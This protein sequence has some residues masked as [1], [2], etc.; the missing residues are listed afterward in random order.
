M[1]NIFEP[2]RL[3]KKC[4]I[5]GLGV[6]VTLLYI[7]FLI[8]LRWPFSIS[9]LGTIAIN[10]FG[11]FLAGV[12]GPIAILWLIL[13]FMLQK[14]E[15]TQNRDA[16]LLQAKELHDTLEQHKELVAATKEQLDAD[17]KANELQELQLQIDTKPHFVIKMFSK[18]S[19]SSDSDSFQENENLKSG[20]IENNRS[21]YLVDFLN[22]GA[23][24]ANVKVTQFDSHD[25]NDMSS[26]TNYYVNTNETVGS[27]LADDRLGLRDEITVLIDFYDKL[28]RFHQKKFFFSLNRKYKIYECTSQD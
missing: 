4:K 1:N 22:D 28:D 27:F 26:T 11:D 5:F 19:L 3:D 14:K 6:T 25:V 18:R 9:T 23:P 7:S 20:F 10:E 8:W 24:A 15:L 21:L 12:F 2:E 17:I 13:S 16:L